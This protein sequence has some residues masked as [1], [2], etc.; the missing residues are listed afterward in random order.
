MPL[1]PWRPFWEIEKWFEEEWPD[2]FSEKF[3]FPKIRTP[4]MD[5]YEI[6]D[7]VVAEVEL[8][9]VKPEDIEVEVKE[10]SLKVKAVSKEEK[11]EKGRDY[12]R[13]ESGE[14]YFKRI[15]SLPTEVVAEKA[16][17]EY[18]DGIL[19]I[20]IPKKAS[21]KEKEKKIKIKVKKKEK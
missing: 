21:K 6:K 9:G 10:D 14:R 13:K 15:S 8:P 18:K 7:K 3:K 1:I 20:E 16:K 11:E 2:L 12:Y 5:I 17:A 4:R 19:R